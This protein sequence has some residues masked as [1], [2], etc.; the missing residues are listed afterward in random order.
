MASQSDEIENL[1][2]IHLIILLT[3]I[4]KIRKEILQIKK[5]Q[6]AIFEDRLVFFNYDL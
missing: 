3:K 1:D 2:A 6:N 4:L 5:L